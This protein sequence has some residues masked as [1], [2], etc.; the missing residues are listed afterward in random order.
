MIGGR[1]GDVGNVGTLESY[2]PRSDSW[3]AWPPMPTP[4]GG[5]A[6]AA[7]GERLWVTGGEVLD[8]SRVTFPQLEVFDPAAGSWGS[9]PSTPSAR[10]GLAAAVRDGELYVLA[11]GR[12]AGLDVSGVN[13][14][15]TPG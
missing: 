2:D 1:W 8:E 15:H 11:G 6:A 9:A 10:H 3:R 14:I 4:R 12:L 7:L 13:E 5:L